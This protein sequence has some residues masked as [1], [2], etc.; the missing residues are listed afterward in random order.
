MSEVTVFEADERRGATSASDAEPD[1]RCPGRHNAQK[2]V[3]RKASGKYAEH[4]RLIHEALAEPA[5]GPVLK[6][7]TV[8][9]RETF[10]RCREIEKK[11]LA[12]VFPEQSSAFPLKIFREQRFWVKVDGKLEHS[13][14]PDLVARCGSRGAIVEYKTLPGDVPESPTNLQL[15]DQ[16]VLAAGHLLLNEVT[17]IVDQPMVTMS[18]VPTLYNAEAIKRAEAEMF[19]RVRRSND[20]NAPRLA[21]E[22]QCEHCRAKEICVEYQ[23][24][25]GAMVPGMLTLLDV[26]VSAWTPDQRAMFLDKRA[27]AQKWLDNCLETIE[28]GAESD[29]NY[30]TGWG[31]VP[32]AERKTITDPQA[33]FN[34][35]AAIGGTVQK[36]MSTVTVGVTKLKEAVNDLTGARGKA[37]DAAIATL[38]E[39]LVEVKRNKASLKRKEEK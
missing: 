10:D 38:T 24:F 35:F 14:K 3:P 21:G 34:R 16:V 31:L 19:E 22:I 17:V 15:R 11:F 7:L 1:L 29:P 2:A 5:G 18:P 30:V 37:L 20:P 9:Q 28:R 39:G 23:K 33:V 13:G 26:P 8:D 27:T 25:A 6:S 12:Q 4:G 36:F 32:G